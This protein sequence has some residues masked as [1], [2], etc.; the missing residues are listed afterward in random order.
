MRATSVYCTCT[1]QRP[2][3]HRLQP[4]PGSLRSQSVRPPG[5]PLTPGDDLLTQP[6]TTFETE[7]IELDGRLQKVWKHVCDRST[8]LGL[9][10]DIPRLPHVP[11]GKVC[12]VRGP[13]PRVLACAGTRAL[14]CPRM[15]DVRRG[16]PPSGRSRGV[17]PREG[18]PV[19]NACGHRRGELYWV[20][21]GLGGD[22]NAADGWFP[23]SRFISLALCRLF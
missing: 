4:W 15:P 19:R 5:G 10:S 2:S 16:L 7:E 21:W 17:A 22:P 18:C 12:P 3:P 23:L 6:G 1:S 8:L 11:H 20:S 14:G 13:Y 9:T